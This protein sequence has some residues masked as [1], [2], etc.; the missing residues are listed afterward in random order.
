MSL[1]MLVE[2]QAGSDYTA[3]D[4]RSWL[5]DIGFR[6]SY[7]EQLAGPDAMVVGIK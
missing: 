1:N 4:C 7:A 2:T 3:A 5:A 6:D